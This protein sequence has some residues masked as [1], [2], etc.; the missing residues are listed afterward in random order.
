[1]YFQEI[2]C[3]P[4]ASQML[5][6][7]REPPQAKPPQSCG[8]S[9]IN[10]GDVEFFVPQDEAYIIHH[11]NFIL[12]KVENF[13]VHH[14]VFEEKGIFGRGSLVGLKTRDI[15]I[16]PVLPRGSWIFSQGIIRLGYPNDRLT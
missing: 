9:R 12:L 4:S 16:D 3:S 10:I 15:D 2:I 1:M 7:L 13:L 14:I 6:D 11:L 5:E 8:L